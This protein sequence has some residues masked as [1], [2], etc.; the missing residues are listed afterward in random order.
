MISKLLNIEKTI[1]EYGYNPENLSTCS[2]KI[3]FWNCSECGLEMLKKFRIANKNNFCLSCSNK[4]NSINSSEKRSK[5][6]KKKV[7]DGTYL[8][9][10]TGKKHSES[11]V[12]KQRKR[13]K[14]KT[15]EEIYG[16]E[17]AG[18]IKE[19][20]SIKNTGDGNP[21]FGKTHSEE[22]KEIISIKNKRSV[23][24]GKDS[25]FYGKNYNKKLTNS[26]FIE[27]ANKKH[28]NLYDYSMTEYNG[29]S[30]HIDVICKKHGIFRQIAN[31][32]LSGCG[33]PKCNNSVGESRIEDF[34][35][36]N[37]IKFITQYKF[38]G[39]FNKSKLPFD[40]YLV[41]C[42]I[43]IEY[44]GEF[45]YKNLGFN[46]LNYQKINDEIKNTFCSNNNIELIRIPYT[47][48]DNINEILELKILNYEQK[49]YL[50]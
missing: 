27:K 39:C 5:T 10:M 28:N 9:P 4:R 44:D 1:I 19:T 35:N 11:T 20:L 14:G 25:N 38:D 33:C 21:F 32:H 30:S 7:E 40:F 47:E 48:L 42:N 2:E 34:L 3:V 46:D 37:G 18:K 36:K 31:T 49:N 17:K 22:T 8:P 23:R 29:T 50:K 24:R 45:H 26:E 43:C 13:L 16:E 15:Y 12:E 41:D 6:M